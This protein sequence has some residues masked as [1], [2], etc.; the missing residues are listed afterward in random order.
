MSQRTVAEEL[1]AALAKAGVE[2]LY[3]VVGDSLNP[4]T[5]AIRRSGK[6]GWVHV[7]HEE[8]AAFAAGAEA[9]LSGRLA[10]CA[11]SCGPGNLH[12]I[13][14]LFDAHRS[15]APVLAIA[16]QIPSSEIGTSYFQETHPDQLFREC[17]HYCELVSHP[18]QM[19]RTAQ[20]AM[21]MR[22]RNTCFFS[23]RLTRGSR[24][25]EKQRST[26][27]GS[28]VILSSVG[29]PWEAAKKPGGNLRGDHRASFFSAKVDNTTA[30]GNHAPP[31]TFPSARHAASFLVSISSPALPSTLPSLPKC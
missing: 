23:R 7:R 1:V 29:Y 4:V 11:G 6:L 26:T 20:M 16:A 21:Q 10:A 9:Q 8:T 5:D 14:G 3:G 17:S 22:S 27:N 15:Y 24:K 19:P 12:L 18:G 13:N 30:C 31:G 28:T 25:D 2:R